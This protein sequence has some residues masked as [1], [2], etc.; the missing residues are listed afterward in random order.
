MKRFVFIA[1]VILIASSFSAAAWA[2]PD[3][4]DKIKIKI[5][6]DWTGQIAG[7]DYQPFLPGTVHEY[8][9][10]NASGQADLICFKSDKSFDFFVQI[11]NVKPGQW[12]EACLANMLEDGDPYFVSLGFAQANSGGDSI[13]A[14]FYRSH[15]TFSAEE[16]T[17]IAFNL[18]TGISCVRIFLAEESG[19]QIVS[20]RD[21]W[22]MIL[23]TEV[24]NGWEGGVDLH[25]LTRK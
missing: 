3:N 5:Y 12:Y 22:G 15:D 13:E 9:Y 1:L 21:E 25:P 24:H 4:F 16:L 20:L 6:T 10:S 8:D 11:N 18:E 2:K 19:S 17:N 23:S 7:C 14:S